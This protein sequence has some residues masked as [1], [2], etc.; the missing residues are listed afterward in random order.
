MAFREALQL[1]HQYIGTEH[2]LLGLV[3]EGE[4]VGAHVLV[5]LGADLSRV[6]QQVIQLMSGYQGAAP[7]GTGSPLSLQVETPSARLVAC[8]F[9][10]KAPPESGQLVSGTNAFICEHCLRRWSVPLLRATPGPRRIALTGAEALTAGE[11]RVVTLAVSGHTNAEIARAM[12]VSEATVEG[13]LRRAYRKLGIRSRR[14]LPPGVPLAP[15]RFSHQEPTR[16]LAFEVVATGPPP[17]DEDAA[18]C[19]GCCGLQGSRD[20]EQRR[21]I[22]PDGRRRRESRSDLA[23]RAGTS[24]RLHR[25]DRGHHRDGRRGPVHRRHPR[26]R[27]VQHRRGRTVAPSTASGRRRGGGRA[28]EDGPLDLLRTDV[29]GRGAMPATVGDVML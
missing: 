12:F 8:S 15:E 10:G 14:D 18:R 29:T 20:P 19:R 25:R 9:C 16:S 22:P 4:G 28:V 7:P 21:T 23:R 1:G 6:R 2:L 17:E 27:V 13:H 3:R 5:S 11:Q 24:G 26:R